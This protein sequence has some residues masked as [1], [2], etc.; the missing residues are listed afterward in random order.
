[1]LECPSSSTGS[2]SEAH[3]KTT[4]IKTP[5]PPGGIIFV[6]AG[7]TAGS[8]THSRTV[9]IRNF[10]GSVDTLS[11]REA[12]SRSAFDY[13]LRTDPQGP[14]PSSQP[15]LGSDYDLAQLVATLW[16]SIPPVTQVHLH[17]NN[18]HDAAI[19][20]LLTEGD[21]VYEFT[22]PESETLEPLGPFI[23]LVRPDGSYGSWIGSVITPEME[24][25]FRI[26]RKAEV[27][28]ANRRIEEK[29]RTG[30][31]GKPRLL[32]KLLWMESMVV[33]D[34]YNHAGIFWLSRKKPAVGTEEEKAA[35][36][37]DWCEHMAVCKYENGRCR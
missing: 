21:K 20:R 14:Q 4:R 17:T 11:P 6:E 31:I 34:N 32:I 35:F 29:K 28:E 8:S 7:P 30:Q 13:K 1:M 18:G 33:Q 36:V 12:S 23:R 5:P 3:L 9:D 25:Q 2:A 37:R 16:P 22:A 15:L 10:D 24:E 27:A 19:L 26:E